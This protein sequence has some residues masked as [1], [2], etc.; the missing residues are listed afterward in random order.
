MPRIDSLVDDLDDQFERI[1][2][3]RIHPQK[4]NKPK[5]QEELFAEKLA[6]FE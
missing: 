1:E 3:A 4:S 5:T 6:V 2:V